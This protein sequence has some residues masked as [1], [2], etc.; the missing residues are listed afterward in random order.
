MTMANPIG[1]PRVSNKGFLPMTLDEYLALLDW[2]GRQLR[3]GKRGA[4]PADL[5]PILERLQIESASWLDAVSCY[6]GKFRTVVGR[7]D[8]IRREALRRG[9]RWLQGVGNAA[10]LFL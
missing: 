9:R 5:A 4:I 3:D 10:A 7:V 2:T 8:A 6:D 1:S